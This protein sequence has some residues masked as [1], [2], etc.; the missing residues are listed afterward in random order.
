MTEDG[1]IQFN[2]RIYVL[3][4]SELKKIIIQEM[5]NVP[6]AGHPQYQKTLT[7]FKKQFYWPGL[8]K[9]VAMY[10]AHYLECHRVKA[11]H[12]HPASLLHPLHI[13]EWKWEVVAI[14]FITKFP[15]T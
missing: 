2:G 3:A 11:E 8:K 15:R 1:I 13:L 10:I 12:K 14:D 4:K 7:A 6:Y 9:E 5:H